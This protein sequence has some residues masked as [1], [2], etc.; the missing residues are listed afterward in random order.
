MSTP[1]F[2]HGCGQPLEVPEDY[3]RKKMRCPQCGVMCDIPDDAARTAPK[4]RHDSKP[5]PPAEPPSRRQ[6]DE[7][8]R[9]QP[10][11]QTAVKKAPAKPSRTTAP[12]P[13]RRPVD[14]DE[15]D[16][17]PYEVTGG[18][19]RKCPDCGKVLEDGAVL[20]LR[21]GLNTETGEKAKQTFQPLK[22][23][24]NT[25]WS[26]QAR[27][28]TFFVGEGVALASGV[29]G[30][31]VGADA[32][33]FVV[34]FLTFTAMLGFLL[35]TWDVLDLDRNAKGR[36]KLTKTW[37]A[38]FWVISVKKIN[39]GE[40]EGVITGKSH[41]VT[42]MDWL[43]IFVL[44]TWGIIPGLIFAYMVFFKPTYYVALVRDHG[45]PEVMLYR[46][47]SEEQMRDVEYV[48]RDAGRWRVDVPPE[49]LK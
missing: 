24:W 47:A 18:P 25:G 33:T 4:P 31:A 35:G 23:H 12:S 19:E 8:T 10:D 1:V 48:V 16:G 13:K 46:G 38:F 41:D 30:I 44:F 11:K 6:A 42:W 20:C 9:R 36:V 21:C 45:N 7:E 43:V 15:D 2:C 3:Q 22:R 39:V 34:C 17:N 5:Q 14:D 37:R 26:P 49:T 28:V 40:Y 32:C 29:T 27:I